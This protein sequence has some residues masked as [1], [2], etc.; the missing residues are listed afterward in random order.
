MNLP[1]T[2]SFPPDWT[3]AAFN[4]NANPSFADLVR[5]IDPNL[6]PQVEGGGGGASVSVPIGT[7]T[8]PCSASGKFCLIICARRFA[9][10]SSD[11]TSPSSFS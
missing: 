8:N 10:P 11:S 2:N 6:L 7:T 9:L 5:G 1:G 3:R 4:F